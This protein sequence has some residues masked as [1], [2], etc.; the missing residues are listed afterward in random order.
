MYTNASLTFGLSFLFS[1][2]TVTALPISF[3]GTGALEGQQNSA[4][5]KRAVP[6]FL[7]GWGGTGVGG[8]QPHPI[9]P[10]CPGCSF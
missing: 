6:L 4:I 8:P 9:L 2:I 1:A 10:R 7:G 5:Q 3:V